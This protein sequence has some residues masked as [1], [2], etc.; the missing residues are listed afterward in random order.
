MD[1]ISSIDEAA[2]RA[3]GHAVDDVAANG[4]REELVG[5]RSQAA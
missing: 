3:D 2:R 5:L 1:A 4:L